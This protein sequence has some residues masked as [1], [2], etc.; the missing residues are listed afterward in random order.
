[1]LARAKEVSEQQPRLSP[2]EISAALQAAGYVTP[3]GNA[4][5]AS[6]IASR[7]T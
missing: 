2:R 1:M 4:Y 7:L 6:A 5:A 3:K